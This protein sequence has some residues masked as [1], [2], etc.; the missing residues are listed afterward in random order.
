MIE[1]A[2]CGEQRC[3]V[4]EAVSARLHVSFRGRPSAVFAA[5]KR[6]YR[7]RNTKA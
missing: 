1:P 5:L 4:L 7:S 3:F 6:F 2:R